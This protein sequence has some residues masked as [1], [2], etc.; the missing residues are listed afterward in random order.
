[1]TEPGA[2][3]RSIFDTILSKNVPNS[4]WQVSWTPSVPCSLSI[5][6]HV[7]IL[8]SSCKAASVLVPPGLAHDVGAPGGSAGPLTRGW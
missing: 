1:M 4:H 3:L 6:S 2:P 7:S 8:P 5:L